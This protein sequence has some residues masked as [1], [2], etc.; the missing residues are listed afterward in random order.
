MSVRRSRLLMGS[1]SLVLVGAG[2]IAAGPESAVAS[3]PGPAVAVAGAPCVASWTKQAVPQIGREDNVLS[4]ITGTSLTDAYAAGRIADT[5]AS[6][7]R[8]LPRVL[9]GTAS[10]W[11]DVPLPDL[12]SRA[13]F[14]SSSVSPAPGAAWVGGSYL[15]A[16]T[17]EP[18]LF[19]VVG[20]VA[21][22]VSLPP[23]P[24]GYTEIQSD[25]GLPLAS[26]GGS[27][28]WLGGTYLSDS[29]GPE[30]S[31]LY[32]PSVGGGWT[33]I[34]LPST[35]TFLS[36][37]AALSPTEAY[38]AACGLFTVSGSSVAAVPLPGNPPFVTQ[39]VARSPSDVWAIVTST[40]HGRSLVHFDGHVWVTQAGPDP[41]VA[42]ELEHLAVSPTGVLWALGSAVNRMLAIGES[43]LSRFDPRSGTWATVAATGDTTAPSEAGSAQDI[44]A[45]DHGQVM[46]AGFGHG[47]A[48]PV[49]ARLC[50][51]P[52]TLAPT[53]PS[54]VS[55]PLVGDGVL[56][57]APAT[58]PGNA[59]VRDTTGL[60]HTRALVAGQAA[61]LTV[62][63]AGTYTLV[64]STGGRVELTVPA[65]VSHVAHHARVQIA[66]QPA[67]PGYA[68][69]LQI[70]AAGTTAWRSTSLTASSG[71]VA[72]DLYPHLWPAGQ[73]EV[74]SRVKNTST[75]VTTGWSPISA[76]AVP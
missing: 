67:P 28:L 53:G 76:A 40:A 58:M 69:V 43:T 5:G 17:F 68:Y 50:Q 22:R 34:P 25:L 6:G 55:V 51:L 38:V 60:L 10:G 41:A 62:N 54:R 36:S 46:M 15:G 20:A 3:S 37:I 52:A 42:G 39:V 31:V 21:T 35:L 63:A 29:L 30:R 4:T 11:A 57:T 73:Y 9:R 45:L 18:L 13:T 33:S 19:H 26:S 47:Q 66:A 27:D 8:Y 70:R 74:R 56:V 48:S 65:W 24:A 7:F 23:P 1:L 32:R 44:L 2:A 59:S 16:T 49:V 75:G 61:G 12:G 71:G 14:L 64:S 72:K